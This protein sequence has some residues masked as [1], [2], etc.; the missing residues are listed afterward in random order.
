MFSDRFCLTQAVIEDRKKMTRRIIPASILAKVPDYQEEYYENTLDSLSFTDALTNMLFVEKLFKS[1][2]QVGDVV[3]VAQSYHSLNRMGY[4]APEWLDHTCEDSPGYENKMFVDAKLMP[5]RI[6]IT[7]ARVERL[8][9][10]SDDDCMKEGIMKKSSFPRKK[11]LPYC[12]PGGKHEWS[13]SFSTP[14]KAYAALMDKISG[15]GTWERNPYVIVYSFGL[16]K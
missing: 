7:G 14:R 5:H 9:D 12:F 15:K 1:V 16:T 8:Q 4:L 2:L 3:A 10:I 11:S 6:Q 13:H